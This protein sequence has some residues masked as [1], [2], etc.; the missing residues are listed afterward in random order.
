MLKVSWAGN[1]GCNRR[2]TEPQGGFQPKALGRLEP[3]WGSME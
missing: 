3:D 2:F 1:R